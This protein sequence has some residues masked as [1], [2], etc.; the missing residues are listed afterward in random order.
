MA[1]TVV[2]NDPTARRI[3]SAARH[4][5]KEM[6]GGNNGDQE[7]FT[8]DFGDGLVAIVGRG[9]TDRN[10]TFVLLRNTNG[11]ECYVYPNAAC[12]GIIVSATR[13]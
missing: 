5:K 11:D 13:P 3:T 6:T 12:T 8:D 10:I 1:F 7:V 4:G 2:E 9:E